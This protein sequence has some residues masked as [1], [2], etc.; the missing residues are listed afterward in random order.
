MAGKK[1]ELGPT[2][3]A[4]RSNIKQIREQRRLS[5]AELSRKLADLGR[6][7]ATLGLS[8]IENGERRVDVDDLTALAAALG[9]SPVLLL[10]PTD[11]GEDDRVHLTGVDMPGPD[12]LLEWLTGPVLTHAEWPALGGRTVFDAIAALE[13]RLEDIKGAEHGNV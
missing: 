6:P 9:V 2:G 4:L 11:V 12:D 3:E 7:I 8:R 1:N 5:Y 13:K 10:M